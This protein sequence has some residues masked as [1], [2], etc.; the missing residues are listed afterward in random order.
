M[1]PMSVSDPSND[2]FSSLRGK[3]RGSVLVSL[4]VA[5]LCTN[6]AKH[7]SA[8]TNEASLTPVGS[9]TKELTNQNVTVQAVISS[10]REPQSARAPYLVSLTESNATLP[11][12]YWSDMQPQLASKVKWETSSA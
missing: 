1:M 7:A 11:L 4:F 2:Q 12:V 8:L 3:L 5:L 9:I 10:I 6:M